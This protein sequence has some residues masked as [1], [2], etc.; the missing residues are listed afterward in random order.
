MTLTLVSR[1]ENLPIKLAL[2]IV[3][4]SLLYGCQPT[5]I[6][7]KYTYKGGPERHTCDGAGYIAASKRL[8]VGETEVTVHINPLT[9]ND[10]YTRVYRKGPYKLSVLALGQVGSHTKM[11]VE[12]LR[13]QSS[14]GHMYTV[15]DEGGLPLAID[16]GVRPGVQN[17][18]DP[19][20]RRFA[21]FEPTTRLDLDFDKEEHL[22][23]TTTLTIYANDTASTNTFELEFYPY[24]VRGSL[25]CAWLP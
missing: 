11:I 13:L 17:L 22:F 14:F 21:S 1:D 9:Y 7:E 6:A 16:F 5:L 12:Q 25:K 15:V 20:S 19:G 18:Q 2:S 24:Y 10:N 8:F 3:L 23:L 4:V